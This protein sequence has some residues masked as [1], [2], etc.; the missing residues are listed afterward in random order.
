MGES[1][2]VRIQF[3]HLSVSTPQSIGPLENVP[4]RAAK[5]LGWNGE[6]GI[7]KALN[8]LKKA[9]PASLVKAQNLLLGKEASDQIS[10]QRISLQSTKHDQQFNRKEKS[11]FSPRSDRLSN[12]IVPNNVSLTSIPF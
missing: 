6:G 8:V 4:E 9:S 11:I 7:S 5:F 12:H 1:V 2:V 3:R 10:L